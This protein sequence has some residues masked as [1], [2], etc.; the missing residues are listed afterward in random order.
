MNTLVQVVCAHQDVD[1]RNLSLRNLA[2]E[3]EI[4][5]AS[6]DQQSLR[7]SSTRNSRP[8]QPFDEFHPAH[9]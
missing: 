9:T 4:R 1:F 5:T 2:D 6:D 7:S 3:L 8:H